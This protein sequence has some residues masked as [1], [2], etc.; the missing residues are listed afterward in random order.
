MNIIMLFLDFQPFSIIFAGN[1][2]GLEPEQ[3]QKYVIVLFSSDL[4]PL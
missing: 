2:L 1:I 4:M 3:L